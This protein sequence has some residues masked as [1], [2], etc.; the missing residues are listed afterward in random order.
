MLIS[1][2]GYVCKVHS[3]GDGCEGADQ[4]TRIRIHGK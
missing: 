4:G 2:I 3:G 1:V